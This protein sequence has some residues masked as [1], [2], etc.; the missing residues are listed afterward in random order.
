MQDEQALCTSMGYFILQTSLWRHFT[1]GTL[2]CTQHKAG[3]VCAFINRDVDFCSGQIDRGVITPNQ[4]LWEPFAFP[5]DV[6]DCLRGLTTSNI[7][8]HNSCLADADG[9]TLLLYSK[10]C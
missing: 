1:G 4:L 6:A 9:D 10:V 8:V 3:P 7:F 5:S 2:G